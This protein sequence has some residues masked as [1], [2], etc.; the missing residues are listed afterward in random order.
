[1]TQSIL[2][3]VNECGPV[4][5]SEILVNCRCTPEEIQSLVEKGELIEIEYVVPRMNYRIKSLLFPKGTEIEIVIGKAR[6]SSLLGVIIEQQQN[7][8]QKMDQQLFEMDLEKNG[9]MA[10]G[11]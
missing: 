10:Q 3:Y 5:A 1:M 4:K 6:L 2:E 8:I 11:C 7:D 9:D